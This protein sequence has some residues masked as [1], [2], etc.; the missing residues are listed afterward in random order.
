MMTKEQDSCDQCGK[1]VPCPRCEKNRVW[2]PKCRSEQ[3]K[4]RRT[5]R[6]RT[7]SDKNN[8]SIKDSEEN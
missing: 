3:F 6:D 2:T 5:K 8:N 1:E 4:D 7:R